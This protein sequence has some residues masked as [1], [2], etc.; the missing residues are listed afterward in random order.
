MVQI[1]IIPYDV[2]CNEMQDAMQVSLIES[3]KMGYL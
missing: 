3:C 2:I 1:K